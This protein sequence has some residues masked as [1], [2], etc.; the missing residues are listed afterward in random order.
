M[1]FERQS[2]HTHFRD[3]NGV[4]L[5]QEAAAT[6]GFSG[7]LYPQTKTLPDRP[8]LL[9]KGMVQPACHHQHEELAP[10]ARVAKKAQFSISFPKRT[11]LFGCSSKR[12]TR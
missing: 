11:T 2:R 6:E 8:Q 7:M 3:T 10:S 9:P 4:S 12:G 1:G 5:G